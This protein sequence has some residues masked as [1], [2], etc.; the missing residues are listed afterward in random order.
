M[1]TETIRTETHEFQIV[2][3]RYLHS[4]EAWEVLY[5]SLNPKTGKPW[6]SVKRVTDGATIEPSGWVIRPIAYPT[7]DAARS[8][9]ERQKAKFAKRS[10]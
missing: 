4:G 7:I 9:V 1:T 6:Q 3:C 2:P 5:R 10:N 8:A